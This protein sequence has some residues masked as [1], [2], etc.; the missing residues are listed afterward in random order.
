MG[1]TDPGTEGGGMILAIDPGLHGACALFDPDARIVMTYDIPTFTVTTNGKQRK[2]LDIHP[3]MKWIQAAT[4]IARA[5]IIEQPNALPKQGVA[6]AFTFG[7][8]CGHL[9]HALYQSGLPL[10]LVKPATWKAKMGITADKDACRKRA[11]ELFPA[12][13][14]QWTRKGG[15]DRAEAALLAYYGWAYAKVIG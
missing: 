15:H 1:R 5:A 10:T 11:S 3:L 2:H 4:L 14:E 8:V 7:K 9:E 6:S 12:S 13:A